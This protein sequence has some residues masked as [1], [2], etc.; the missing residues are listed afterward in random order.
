MNKEYEEDKEDLHP[1]PYYAII[2]IKQKGD[3]I[4]DSHLWNSK[5]E[6]EDYCNSHPELNP[7]FHKGWQIGNKLDVDKW[8][9]ASELCK[10][11]VKKA[12]IKKLSLKEFNDK[13]KELPDKL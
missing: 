3:R 8:D 5:K 2:S 4:Y 13:I 12:N 10:E 1:D 7:I 11:L 6:V 9:K